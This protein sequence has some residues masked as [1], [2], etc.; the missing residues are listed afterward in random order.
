MAGSGSDSRATSL[1]PTSAPKIASFKVS[2]KTAQPLKD[3]N[4]YP[5]W[6]TDIQRIF[7]LLKLKDA[8]NKDT[9]IV[10][11]ADDWQEL[12]DKTITIILKNCDE[13][14]QDLIITCEFAYEAW[15]ILKQQI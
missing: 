10:Y 11:S 12:S 4:N 9:A 6:T 2:R 3:E 8:L 7:R 5:A 15:T 1:E 13:N 14:V